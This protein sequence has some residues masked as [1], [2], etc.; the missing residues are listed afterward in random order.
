MS[1]ACE[2]LDLR[3]WLGQ[4][5]PADETATQQ[6][7][8]A[9]A[10]GARAAYANGDGS[11]AIVSPVAA[12]SGEWGVSIIKAFLYRRAALHIAAFYPAI[13]GQRGHD[14]TFDAACALVKG[15]DLTIDEARP[16]LQG[17][18][19][20]CSPPWADH[21][22]EHKL[23]DADKK[24]DDPAKPRGY[25]RDADQHG[26]HTTNGHATQGAAAAKPA[27][28]PT[29]DVAAL[30]ARA[31]ELIVGGKF[32]ELCRAGD[33]HASLARLE[34]EDQ[35]EAEAIKT[36][37]R[38]ISGY[39]ERAFD[40]LMNPHREAAQQELPAQW[41]EATGQEFSDLGNG[42]R[43][44]KLFGPRIRFC[45]P[46]GDWL[47]YDGQRWAKDERYAIEAMAQTIPAQIIYE[48]PPSPSDETL[49][50]HKK[51]ALLT[52]SKDRMMALIHSARSQVAIT[53]LDLDRDPWLLNVQNGTL[54][55]RTGEFR[56]HQAGDLITKIA[57]V[58]YDPAAPAPNWEKFIL[59]IMKDNPE[60]AGYL[61][62]AVGYSITGVIR[63]H[64][65]FFLHGTGSNG[66]TTFLNV[67]SSI[68]GDYANEIDSDLLIS[69]N[70]KQHPTGLTELEGRRLVSA[71]EADEGRRL[72]EAQ[73][74]KLTGGNPIQARRMNENFYTFRPSH[75]L[76]FAANHKPEIRGMDTGIWRRV[77]LI[78]FE[79][80]FDPDDPKSRKP[81]LE[82]EGKLMNE[83][84]GILNWMLCGCRE[85]QE[86]GLAEPAE[87]K[88]GV[89]DYRQEMDTLG[90][91][92][93]ERYVADAHP[94]TG[95]VLL[96]S[97]YAEYVSWCELSGMSPIGLRKFSGLLS[98]KGFRTFKSHSIV[99]KLGL[100]TKT[101][102]ER[103]AERAE[104]TQG[105]GGVPG[106]E[107]EDGESGY[108]YDTT[109]EGGFDWKKGSG[110]ERVPKKDSPGTRDYWN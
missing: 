15:F 64:V 110:T 12:N 36:S 45:K 94:V 51:W 75:H 55:L 109:D 35:P 83:A 31:D 28:T 5:A 47:I 10:R 80:S 33:F 53:P 77:K 81:D 65:F 87:V 39:R 50:A 7:P 4:H 2:V 43:L 17:W 74:K 86:R 19:T 72:A 99:Y 92:I 63:E 58:S 9:G 102:A 79:V 13:S 60:L 78:P 91:F 37:L 6:M 18:N 107:G 3:A 67:L 61:R 26:P 59:E 14:Q 44:V 100:R 108:I 8:A 98:D 96:S 66:K 11:P 71:D 73:V 1:V 90:W 38:R 95:R 69:Q 54:N 24:L 76:F 89:S 104:A 106:E 49:Q 27:K 97:I 20:Q 56:P 93:D 22:L 30:T 40:K 52:Q 68:L 101:E 70:N 25:L 82:L 16:I 62:R 57:K 85:W 84:P 29:V 46:Y 42:R 32:E 103:A 105:S 21:E 41:S 34:I 48:I 88:E 23:I